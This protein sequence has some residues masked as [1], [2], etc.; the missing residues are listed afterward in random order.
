MERVVWEV[1]GALRNRLADETVGG[2]EDQDYHPNLAHVEEGFFIWVEAASQVL[3]VQVP[4]N[5][6]AVVESH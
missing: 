3:E 2:K 4:H 6:K 1:V 5:E